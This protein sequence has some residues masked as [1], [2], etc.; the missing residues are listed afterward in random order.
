MISCRRINE[1][2]VIHLEY[3]A[4]SSKALYIVNLG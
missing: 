4:L 3:L 2:L 1:E